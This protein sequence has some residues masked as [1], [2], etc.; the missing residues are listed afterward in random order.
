[1]NEYRSLAVQLRICADSEQ[2]CVGCP[3]FGKQ[4]CVDMLLRQAAD[5]IEK[6][7]YGKEEMKQR[8]A[9]RCIRIEDAINADPFLYTPYVERDDRSVELLKERR[10]KT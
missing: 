2:S 8:K 1:M 9:K 3:Y 5:V 7:T 10:Y 6:V 4:S